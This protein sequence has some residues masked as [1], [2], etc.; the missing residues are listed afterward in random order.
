MPHLSL[1]VPQM[2]SPLKTFFS[3]RHAEEAVP[4]LGLS[5][6]LMYSWLKAGSTLG[7]EATRDTASHLWGVSN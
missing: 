6:P 3:S 4:H 7:E 2:C 1:P 5:L